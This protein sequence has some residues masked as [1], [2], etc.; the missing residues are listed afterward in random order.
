MLKAITERYFQI[1]CAT[2]TPNT[3][4]LNHIVEMAETLKANGV[5]HYAIQFCQ[6][7]TIESKR[8]EDMLASKGIPLLRLETDYSMQD[9]E[10]LKTR[11]EAF[12]ELISP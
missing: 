4:R 3:E 2:F 11:I 5:I 7:Y 9:V 12:K 10:A 6:P 8:V 1:D